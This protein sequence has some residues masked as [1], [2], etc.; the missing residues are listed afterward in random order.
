MNSFILPLIILLPAVLAAVTLIIPAR[1]K[2]AKESL[3]I[4][5][6]TVNLIIAACLYGKVIEFTMPLC[7]FGIDFALRVYH[8][9][10]FIILAAS[11]F[12]FLTVLYSTVFMKGK[13]MSRQFFA[14]LLFT[15]AL[16]NGA[17]LANNL[18]VLL[19]FWEGLLVTMFAMIMTGGG[20]AYKTSVKMLILVG[21]SDLCMMLGIGMTGYI[22]G[23]LEI[24]K[25]SSLPLTSWG[26]FAF[27]LL[28]IGAVTKAGSMPFHTWI[29]D[30]ATDAP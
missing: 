15:V 26:I 5:G 4:I 11:G 8:F 29:P 30:A 23:T 14:Y 12:S 9:S 27:V 10:A 13:A 16:V 28:M 19:F 17:V 18:V 22:A 6:V 2:G 21:L 24:D 1:V 25:I 20:S 7:G 3:A